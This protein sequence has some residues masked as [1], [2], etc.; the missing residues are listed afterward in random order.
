MV[1]GSKGSGTKFTNLT[2]VGKRE[3]F[4]LATARNRAKRKAEAEAR[5][6]AA[7]AKFEREQA[8]ANAIETDRFDIP[9]VPFLGRAVIQMP[10][11]TNDLFLSVTNA[12]PAGVLMFVERAKE[13]KDLLHGLTAAEREQRMREIVVYDLRD[14]AKP[15]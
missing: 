2:K 5:E 4:R 14:G 11:T 1:K 7:K 8:M 3:Y 6:V 13:A 10:S 15:E 9:A 12:G